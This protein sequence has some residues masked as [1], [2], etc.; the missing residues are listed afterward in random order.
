[1]AWVRGL[2]ERIDE[3]LARLRLMHN[4]GL[5]TELG[6]AIVRGRRRLR[7]PVL[8]PSGLACAPPC[9]HDRRSHTTRRG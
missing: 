2:Q 4:S 8:G 1:V 5:D 3:P 6:E 9:L 7:P